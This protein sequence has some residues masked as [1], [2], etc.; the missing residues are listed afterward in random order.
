M[1]K[2][3]KNKQSIQLSPENYIR[4][5]A[6]NLPIYKCL[7]SE[8]WKKS[9]VATIFIV[10]QHVSGNLTFA[11]YVVDLMC[12][13][14][15][16]STYKYN[17]PEEVL[18]ALHENAGKNNMTLVEIPYELAHNII[19]S[20]VEYAAEYGFEPV[21]EFTSVTQY[22]L[23][24]DD[25]TIPLIDIHCG[26]RDGKPLYIN[27]G[28]DSPAK[29]QQT[30]KQLEKTAGPGNYN[31]MLPEDV[32]RQ[33]EAKARMEK[34]GDDYD[35]HL[36]DQLRELDDEELERQFCDLAS[37]TMPSERF[38]NKNEFYARIFALADVVAE[39]LA[40]NDKVAEQFDIIKNDLDV[41]IIDTFDLPN[42]F[43]A[44]LQ[45]NDVAQ[46][47]KTWFQ[48]VGKLK[49]G[50]ITPLEELSKVTG[51]IPVIKYL[52]LGFTDYPEEEYNRKLDEYSQ[53]YPDYLLFKMIRYSRTPELRQKVKSLLRELNAPVTGVEYIEFLQ[54]YAIYLFREPDLT[55]EKLLAFE[56]II[57]T[58]Q[59]S[60]ASMENI[61]AV[62]VIE[63]TNLVKIHYKLN[64]LK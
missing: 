9:N 11:T 24:D 59:T 54:R 25:D 26:G 39:R 49:R 3:K 32:K 14:V 30:L 45:C 61:N 4:Q 41:E 58:F 62:I 23:E 29:E 22:L 51:D 52:E 46:F 42:S 5:R 12:M 34:K 47:S 31:Y 40:D 17:M 16:D 55:L 10:R 1:S 13:G 33:R 64:K 35:E 48:L 60:D 63:K 43:F 57:Q 7:I 2:Q 50:N 28:F 21:P 8:N 18:Q 53:Q 15:K 38:P 44:G 27:T 36:R 6:R 56:A 37:E 19:Y 20:A